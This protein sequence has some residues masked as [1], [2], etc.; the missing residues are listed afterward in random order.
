MK[1]EPGVVVAVAILRTHVMTDLPTNTV[2]VEVARSDSVQIDM[3]ALA[4][5]DAA[6]IVAVQ[7]LVIGAIA[8]KADILDRD[9]GYAKSI[10]ERKQS[11]GTGPAFSPEVLDQHLI[12]L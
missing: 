6:H 12:E 8:V 10:E 4:E 1:P 9:V 3:V 5:K 11:G 7:E 2:A